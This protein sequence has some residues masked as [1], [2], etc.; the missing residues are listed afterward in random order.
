MTDTTTTDSTTNSTAAS[1]GLA[2]TAVTDLQYANAAGTLINATVTFTTLGALPF[3][4]S[5]D[6]TEPH[7]AEIYAAVMAG[8]Y[9]TIAAYAAVA[10][11][12]DSAR[13]WRDSEVT[14]S[15]WLVERHRDQTDAGT[16][17]TL[18]TAEYSALLVYRQ[19]LRDWP[20]ATDFPAD[21]SKPTAPDW[22]A[23]A[24]AAADVA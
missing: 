1:T 11:T 15:Q 19:A 13:I 20:T 23:A 22:L 9:G 2:Y 8:T 7:A 10:P 16:T 12:A 14:A 4:V 17:T 21:S 6:D 5:A 18:T 3:T 24:E